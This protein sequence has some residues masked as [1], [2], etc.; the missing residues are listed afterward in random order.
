[1]ENMDFTVP[2][3]TLRNTPFRTK[4][5]GD[6]GEMK[7][8]MGIGCISDYEPQPLLFQ[9]GLEALPL[10]LWER[11]TIM[12]NFCMRMYDTT[13]V[14]FQEMTNGTVNVT[15][16]VAA[17]IC[18]KDNFVKVSSMYRNVSTVP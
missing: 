15:E 16:L 13:K 5:D 3:T 11:S 8:N 7:G 9:S 2:S 4:F 6:V 18:E 14:H 10:L 12:M 17:L 1:M